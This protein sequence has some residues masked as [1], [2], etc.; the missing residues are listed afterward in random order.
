MWQ[1]CPL[2]PPRTEAGDL[3]TASFQGRG[4]LE[5]VLAPSPLRGE[6]ERGLWE[7]GGHRAG[8]LNH[9]I[10][11]SCLD[12]SSALGNTLPPDT[13][14]SQKGKLRG[15]VGNETGTCPNFPPQTPDLMLPMT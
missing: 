7:A 14:I 3:I 10:L 2:Y 5:S 6:N 12:T 4:R 15:W 11:S 13:P 8:N 1:P 9:L